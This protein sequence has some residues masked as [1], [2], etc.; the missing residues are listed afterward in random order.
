V[1]TMNYEWSET[2]KILV[3]LLA[4]LFVVGTLTALTIYFIK[5]H[6]KTQVENRGQEME[7]HWYVIHPLVPLWCFL[8]CYLLVVGQSSL[9]HIW[10]CGGRHVDDLHPSRSHVVQ[11]SR[12][13]QPEL[14]A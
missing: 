12:V 2:D 10:C 9:G 3:G 13:L 7:M 5:Y 11:C 4:A 8:S 14:R 6:W 1:T